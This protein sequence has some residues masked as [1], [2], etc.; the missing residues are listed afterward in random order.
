LGRPLTNKNGSHELIWAFWLNVV[1]IPSGGR[2]VVLLWL[3]QCPC[4]GCGYLNEVVATNYVAIKCS[5]CLK[6]KI[7]KNNE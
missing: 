3:V 5:N 7:E 2:G 1:A 4:R 6:R